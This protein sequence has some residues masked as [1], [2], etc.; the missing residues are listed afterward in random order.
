MFY[1]ALTFGL[2]DDPPAAVER[3]VGFVEETGRKHGVEHPIQMTVATSD[4]KQPLGVPLLERARLALALLQHPRRRTAGPASRSR[5]AGRALRRVAARRLRAARRSRGRLECGSRSRAGASC[6]RARTRSTRSRRGV[7]DSRRP[8]EAIVTHRR[9][10]LD[11]P[12]APEGPCR[13]VERPPDGLHPRGRQ[14]PAAPAARHG[15]ARRTSP[16]RS[17]TTS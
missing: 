4:G 12:E 2:E 17:S 7:P 16:T 8:P 3:M 14:H 13:A 1:L 5:R 9:Y 11:D 10:E 6:T 15:A